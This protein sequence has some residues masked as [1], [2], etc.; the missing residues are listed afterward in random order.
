MEIKITEI[1]GIAEDLKKKGY[2]LFQIC[3]L[4]LDSGLIELNY[5]FEKDYEF[6]NYK[7]QIEE[8]LEIPSISHI[9]TPAFMYENELHDLF[10][11]NIKNIVIDFKGKFYKL[12]KPHPFNLPKEEK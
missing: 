8:S 6:L 7:V 5:S 12:A 11:L 1:T 3:A 2:R 10:N 9:F 4:K